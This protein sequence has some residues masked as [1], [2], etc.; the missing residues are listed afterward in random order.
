M[1]E[2][3]RGRSQGLWDRAATRGLRSASARRGSI[4]EL[5]G[6]LVCTTI[7]RVRAPFLFFFATSIIAVAACGARTSLLSDDQ[8][9]DPNEPVDAGLDGDDGLDA[10]EDPDV[11]VLEP[12]TGV[13]AC[14]SAGT[15]YIYLLS[16]NKELIAFSPPDLSVATI[17]TIKCP[18][19]AGPY[20][21]AVSPDG[22][23]YVLFE[24]GEIFHVSTATAACN[25]TGF[26]SNPTRF[27]PYFGMG[28]SANAGSQGGAIFIAS[29]DLDA[30]GESS[31]G[32]IDPGTFE[33]SVIGSLNKTITSP[34]LTGTSDARLFGF[35]Q[36]VPKSHLAEIDKN[37]G[38][39]KSDV[40][41]NLHQ[42]ETGAWALAFWGSDFF[43]FTSDR[44]D[45]SSIHRYT[46][47]GSTTPPLVA[48]INRTIV[49]AGVSACTPLE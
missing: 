37:T 15:T 45:A 9:P 16:S 29:T 3:R 11:I 17:G 25:P 19:N 41:V 38:A 21:M 20:S 13:L 36:M 18:T 2:A 46:P 28:F 8:R 33:L 47:G 35:S 43:F 42:S 32:R 22:V 40:L 26:V 30:V 24:S 12:K 14:P 7:R 49:G 39:I 27:S 23:A 34:E 6:A 5:T 31:F 48:K 10:P 44:T 4:G 1:L